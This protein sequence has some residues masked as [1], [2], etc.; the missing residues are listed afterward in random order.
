MQQ[1]IDRKCSEYTEEEISRFADNESDTDIKSSKI[2][3]HIDTC[4][5]CRDL[6]ETYQKFSALLTRHVDETELKLDQQSLRKLQ[7]IYSKKERQQ[8]FLRSLT[9]KLIPESTVL[10]FAAAAVLFVISF[11]AF[12][13]TSPLSSDPS[14][15]VKYIDTDFS[16]VMIIET[17]NKHHT[18]IW[19]AET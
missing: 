11:L 2:A 18:I 9:T 13:R 8:G 6:A 12:P 4:S 7:S 17:Q 15:V 16:S 3:R 1:N 14:A 5:E 10:K 19:F